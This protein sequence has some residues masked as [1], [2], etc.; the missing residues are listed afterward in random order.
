MPKTYDI[1]V[2]GKTY[3]L[4]RQLCERG[5]WWDPGRRAWIAWQVADEDLHG[6]RE[7][8]RAYGLPLKVKTPGVTCQKSTPKL[9]RGQLTLAD[10]AR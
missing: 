4:K 8:C 7:L 1:E 9:R 6:I 10:Y 5:L 3:P 2:R